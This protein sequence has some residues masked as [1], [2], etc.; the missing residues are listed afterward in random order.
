MRDDEMLIRSFK[1][2]DEP[3]VIELWRRCELVRTNNDPH[4]DIARKMKVRPDLFLVGARPGGGYA[5]Y[6]GT[7]MAAPQVAGVAALAGPSEIYVSSTVKDLV[8]GSGIVL[9]SRGAAVLKGV[10]GSWPLF[11]VR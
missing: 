8:A 6:S 11:A 1:I 7:S 10:P 2:T 3:A 9:E 5:T 4:K